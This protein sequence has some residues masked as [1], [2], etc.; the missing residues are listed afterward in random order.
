MF[1][2]ERYEEMPEDK[3]LYGSHYSAP[4]FVLFYLVRL[5]PH[6]MLC[7]NNGSFDKPDR[8]FNRYTETRSY[9]MCI[10]RNNVIIAY[11]MSEEGGDVVHVRSNP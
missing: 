5:Y 3:F 9:V 4:G 11:R 8:M 2:Q 7:M 10:V 6:L 1:I